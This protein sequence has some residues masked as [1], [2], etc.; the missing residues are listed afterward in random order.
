MGIKLMTNERRFQCLHEIGSF[1]IR[2]APITTKSRFDAKFKLQW[3]VLITAILH[4]FI[5]KLA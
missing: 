1:Q 5:L 2:S 4:M 3:A